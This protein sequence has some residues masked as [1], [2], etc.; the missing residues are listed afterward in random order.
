M[1]RAALAVAIP[2]ACCLAP[3]AARA[4]EVTGSGS[5]GAGMFGRQPATTAEVGIDLA[6]P[7]YAL[8]LGARGRWLSS[9]GFRGE[10]WDELSEQ[11]RVVR[12]GTAAWS[13]GE[14]GGVAL[15]AALGELGAVSLGHR[16]IIDG[17]SSGLDVD[18]G[19]LGAQ[20]RAQSG[21][22][23]GEL[24]VDD[25]VAARIAGV[26]VAT[27]APGDLVLGVSLAG[28]RVA[29]AM[30]GADSAVV[31]AAALDGELRARS[32]GDGARGALT[33]D[34]VGIAGLAA[35]LHLG[36][37]G[38]ALVAGGVRLGAR[39]ELRAGSR[40]YLPGWIG[41][42][43]EIERRRMTAADGAMES[44]QLDVA[45]AGGLFGIGA[46]GGLTA[47]ADGLVSGEVG[48]A[49]RRGVSDL[50]TARVLAPFHD[51]FQAG[52]WSAAAV[53]G[54]R[55]DALALAAEARL[56]LRSRMFLRAD[57]ARLVRDDD[58]LLRPV[59]LA[60]LAFGASLGD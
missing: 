56:I 60:Q 5:L 1:P 16:A 48:Y 59:W 39:A 50:V 44:G 32:E 53:D 26:R 11:A 10:E 30:E 25:L 8:G 13:D 41:P 24:V 2:L 45:R 7:G 22:V 51:H 15:S 46:A 55:L 38:D 27:A 34:L 6:G 52:L 58:G 47:S 57:A 17:Y 14:P 36:A 20:A 29:P 43:Y 23:S 42:L 37:T 35:G 21:R 54:D 3:A 18:H 49:A 19:H 4:Q 31:A 40:H 33:A 28:D 9:D 12:Y